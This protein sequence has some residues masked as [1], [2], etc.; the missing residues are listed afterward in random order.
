MPASRSLV[1]IALAFTPLLVGCQSQ[2]SSADFT[3]A[4][5]GKATAINASGSG[6]T[7]Q[8]WDLVADPSGRMTGTAAYRISDDEMLTGTNAEG[9]TVKGDSERV[10]G[11]IDYE[12]GR[13]IMV[14]TEENG[15]VYG[16]LMSDGRIKITRAQ[17]GAQP[18]VV[19]TI[20]TRQAP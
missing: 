12:T 19:H 18:V 3:G 4:W 9:K 6:E 16:E 5:T 15:T 2:S 11:M 20:L 13:F 8:F 7:S 10:I 14:E 1:L 17:P